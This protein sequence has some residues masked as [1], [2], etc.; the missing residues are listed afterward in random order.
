MRRNAGAV[1]SKRGTPR[2]SYPDALVAK[3]K[4]AAQANIPHKVIHAISGVSL[5]AIGAYAAG[6]SRAS[7][8]PDMRITEILRAWF[9][10]ASNT[11][12]GSP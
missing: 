6:E 8:E 12:N 7:V 10:I 4:G 11:P 3:V 5:S 9:D 1:V 2:E